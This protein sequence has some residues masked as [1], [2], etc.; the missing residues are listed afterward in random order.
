MGHDVRNEY[1]EWLLEVIDIRRY[2][3]QT[4][5]FKLMAFLH[6]TDFRYIINKDANRASDGID[7]RYR[8]SLAK[9]YY[10]GIVDE[11]DGPCSVLEMMVALAVRCEEA[12]M[13]DPALGDRTGQWFWGMINS[14]GLG[15]LIDSRFDKRFAQEVIDNFLDRKYAPNGYGGLFTIKRCPVDLRTVEIWNQLCWYLDAF[16]D[17]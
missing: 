4:S 17:Y 16:S 14:L 9:G 3:E 6:N 12:I 2:S 11:L 10:G 15:G 13:D 7:L 8:F 1:F 5:F